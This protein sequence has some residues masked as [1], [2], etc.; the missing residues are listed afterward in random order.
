MT[1]AKR[2]TDKWAP[3]TL[4]KAGKGLI[5]ACPFW[6]EDGRAYV[7]H[8]YAGSRAGMKSILGMFEMT[9]DGTKALTESRLVFDGHPVHTLLGRC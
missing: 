3:L 9:P 2:V 7:A 4:V 5:D 8:G 6:D 1:K